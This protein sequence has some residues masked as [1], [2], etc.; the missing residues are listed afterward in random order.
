MEGVLE[1]GRARAARLRADRPQLRDDAEGVRLLD[2][3][4]QL[5]QLVL[6]PA[7]VDRRPGGAHDLRVRCRPD[8]LVAVPELLVQLL[9]GAPADEADAD[10]LL[11]VARQLD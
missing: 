7:A 5:V 6:E 8:R 1:N 2:Q 10:L 9:A 11:G 3:P 4:L